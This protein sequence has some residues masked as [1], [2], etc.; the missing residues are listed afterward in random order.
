MIRALIT[1]Y[2][3]SENVINN[4]AAI[5]KQA[6][7]VYICDNSSESNS[8]IFKPGDFDN[9]TEYLFFGENLGLSGAFNRVLKNKDVNWL[10][11]D[12]VFFFDQDTFIGPSHIENMIKEY[13][14]LIE[15]GIDLGCLGPTFFNTSN[16]IV[17]KP[18]FKKDIDE[19]TWEVKGVITSSMLSTYK[20]LKTAGFWND[21]VFLDLA[22][23]ELCWRLIEKGLKCVMTSKVVFR[24]SIGIGEKRVGAIHLRVG[25]P[26]R[27]Y[28]Q[29][30]ECLYLLFKKYTPMRYRIRFLAM[31]FIRN[32]LH[33]IF[34]EGRKTRFKYIS[35]GIKDYFKKVKGPLDPEFIIKNQ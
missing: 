29:M 27:E 6:D 14:R 3:P 25:H 26:F 13:E 12:Y 9:K 8:D 4:V 22:D 5:S 20:N 15:K 11:E 30:R 32:P 19:D 1:V 17:E 23:W 10:D 18:R 7:I 2:H 16:N 31:L 21:N 33:L 24:H 28:Y 35:K 34:L